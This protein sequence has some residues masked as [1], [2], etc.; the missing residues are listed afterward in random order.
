[1]R[2][3]QEPFYDEFGQ[4]ITS[5]K[6]IFFFISEQ[7]DEVAVGNYAIKQF[8]KDR[9]D[10]CSVAR[11][12][13][14]QIKYSGHKTIIQRMGDALGSPCDPCIPY[15]RKQYSA[16]EFDSGIIE[17]IDSNMCR[18]IT[19]VGESINNSSEQSSMS[20]ISKYLFIHKS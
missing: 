1:M 16:D 4:I 20:A 7:V 2:S 12:L 9:H 13:S 14:H 18:N 19:T 5:Y 3:Q 15:R 11:Y 10:L 6:K 8:D 17:T